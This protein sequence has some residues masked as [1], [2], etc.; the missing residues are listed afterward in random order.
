MTPNPDP[1]FLNR[2]TLPPGF[3]PTLAYIIDNEDNPL[4]AWLG[5]K[6]ETDRGEI[7]RAVSIPKADTEDE[8]TLATAA[9]NLSRAVA[10]AYADLPPVKAKHAKEATNAPDAAKG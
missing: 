6:V 2:L 3:K 5:V 9:V 10:A 4:G 7:D 8:I 1:T